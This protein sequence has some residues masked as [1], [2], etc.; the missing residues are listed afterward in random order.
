VPPRMY[1]VPS[2]AYL[3]MSLR[4]EAGIIRR[5]RTAGMGIL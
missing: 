5:E 1:G 2:V 4:T 3:R